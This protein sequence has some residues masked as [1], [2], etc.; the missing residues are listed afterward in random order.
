MNKFFLTQFY[1]VSEN[2]ASRNAWPCVNELI[3][4][5]VMCNCT[6]KLLQ[7]MKKKR[8]RSKLCECYHWEFWQQTVACWFPCAYVC[9]WLIVNGER[10]ALWGL[11]GIQSHPH[12]HTVRQ[13]ERVPGANVTVWKG[14]KTGGIKRHRC[15]FWLANA[16]CCL[17]RVYSRRPFQSVRGC[18]EKDDRHRKLVLTRMKLFIQKKMPSIGT[19]SEAI[20]R[21]C[22]TN[23]RKIL[24][25]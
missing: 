12:C 24:I 13:A 18:N 20:D 22:K 3:L 11:V 21:S 14:A 16:I 19:D 6:I 25:Y 4:A 15:Y 10:V 1:K 2:K 5:L 8:N 17:L 9:K 23:L 7:E